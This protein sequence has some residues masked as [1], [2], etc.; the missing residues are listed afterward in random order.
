MTVASSRRAA[1]ALGSNQGNRLEILQGALDALAGTDGVDIEAVSGVYETDPVGGPQ[2]PD[3]LNA[4]VVVVTSL[5]ARELLARAH[6]IEQEFGRVRTE[7]WGP[8]T[9]DVDLLVVGDEIVDEPDLVV[10]HPRS[11]E[12]AFVLVPWL[13]AD[14]EATLPG[15]GPVADLIADLDARGVR[16]RTDVSLNPASAP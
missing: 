15:S 5:S 1:L 8:R 16:A 4:V 12:R 7:R 6:E 10:P 3:Y 13:D 2:Q 9:L 11:A 14:P